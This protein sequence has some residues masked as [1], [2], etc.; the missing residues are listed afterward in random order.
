M[1]VN[2]ALPSSSMI[3]VPVKPSCVAAASRI[4][5]SV[6]IGSAEASAIDWNPPPPIE[7]FAT[8]VPPISS[9]FWMNWRSEPC[10]DRLALPGSSSP[11][12]FEVMALKA[13]PAS[14]PV[15]SPPA[16]TTRVTCS[17]VRRL[18]KSSEA[19]ALRP[20]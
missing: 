17:E 16:R 8:C 15:A 1:N 6:M 4:T 19:T 12:R 14:T 20:P 5:V 10:T 7:K 3:G 9:E 13:N 2:T 11:S 18:E